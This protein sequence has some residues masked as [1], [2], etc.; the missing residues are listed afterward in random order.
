MKQQDRMREPEP[1]R[2]DRRRDYRAARKLKH[3]SGALWRAMGHL[4]N[5]TRKA[6][7]T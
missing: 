2:A 4:L 5:E 1:P 3:S 6:T 7:A